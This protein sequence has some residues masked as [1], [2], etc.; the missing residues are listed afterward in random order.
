MDRDHVL[1]AV[2]ADLARRCGCSA[3]DILHSPQL[4]DEFLSNFRDRAGTDW[5]EETV[6]RRLTNLRK[7]SKL[8]R[9]GELVAAPAG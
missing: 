8:P 3:D 7:R 4:R 9:A 1:V 6:L 5:D 2:Y